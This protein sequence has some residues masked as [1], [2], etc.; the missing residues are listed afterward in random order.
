MAVRFPYPRKRDNQAQLYV[1]IDKSAIAGTAAALLTTTF[2]NEWMSDY[3]FDLT[4]AGAETVKVQGIIAGSSTFVDLTPILESTGNQP[5]A[6]QALVTGLYRLPKATF[7]QFKQLKFTKSSTVQ[8]CT[9][10]A[11]VCCAR[12]QGALPLGS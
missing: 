3:R 9:L 2:V 4:V 12:T 1:T 6:P 5:A 11:S 10:I 7:G 8:A